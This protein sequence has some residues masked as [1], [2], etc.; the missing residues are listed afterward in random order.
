MCLR[1]SRLQTADRRPQIKSFIPF[2][3]RSLLVCGLRSA[4]CSPKGFTL[5]EVLIAILI[6]ATGMVLVIEGM[7]RTEQAIRVSQNLV[8][9]SM[10]ASDQ[11]V[12][13]QLEVREKH[14][15]SSGSDQGSERLP[16]R[17]FH[18]EKKVGP[19]SDESLEDQTKL[20]QVDVE[21]RWKEGSRGENLLKLSSI[22]LNREKKQ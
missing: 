3:N 5:I 2:P 4:V 9:A 7:G 14:K 12:K 17:N 19:Y 21:V 10:I 6:L 18:W 11:L 20:N 16:G 8:T 1:N 22:I 15:L 13:S